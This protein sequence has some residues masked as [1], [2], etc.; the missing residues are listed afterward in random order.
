MKI[1]KHK[2]RKGQA[3]VEAAFVLFIVVLFTFAITE[4]GRAMYIKNML[5]NAARAGARQ[6]VVTGSLSVN[7]TCVSGSSG[8]DYPVASFP[9][10]PSQIS[11][12]TDLIKYNISRGLFAVVPEYVY[13]DICCPDCSTTTASSGKTITVTVTAPFDPVIKLFNDPVNH[14]KLQITDKLVGQASMRY[15]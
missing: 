15:E 12:S 5:N 13:A 1:D 9:Y 3:L 8:A 4:F 2:H 6:A 10:K 7:T 11:A 14:P